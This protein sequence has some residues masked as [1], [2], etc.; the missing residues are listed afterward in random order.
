MATGRVSK[1]KGKILDIPANA[2]TI[3]TASPGGASA[4]VAFTPP[5]DTS[6]GG[7]ILRYRAISNPDSITGTSTS[8]PITVSGL[9]VGTSYTFTVAS[10]NPSGNSPVSAASNSVV[11]VAPPKATGGTTSYDGT[12][13]YHAFTSSGT[14]TPTQSITANILVV[15]G[16]GGGAGVSG[17]GGGGAGGLLGFTSQSLTAQNYTVT[18]GSG[19]AGGSNGGGNNGNNS[20]FGALT[21]AVGGGRANSR[22]TNG[23]LG[24]SGGGGS[25]TTDGGGTTI[26]GGPGTAGQGN[27]GGSGR[28]V[29]GGYESGGG[30]GGASEVGENGF[31]NATGRGGNGSSDYSSWGSAT[32]TGENVSGTRY[33]AGGGAGYNSSTGGLGGGGK[34][35]DFRST[36][37]KNGLVNTGG[38][39]AAGQ[40][41][42][43]SGGTGGSGIVIVRYAA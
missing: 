16:G 38:G 2:P 15:A 12:F 5:A 13:W 34:A 1:V 33:Y 29:S 41:N 36:A 42:L 6:V 39:G 24:G 32:S 14:F 27:T 22:G 4:S 35:G 10:S 7:P 31:S 19:G 8:S 25:A 17:G 20:Q 23:T 28:H 3:G 26:I 21:V 37:D 40:T 43:H 9:T 11:P 18:I 30:G